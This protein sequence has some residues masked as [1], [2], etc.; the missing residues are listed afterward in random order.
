MASDRDL[1]QQEE[2]VAA[3]GK[4]VDSD[5]GFCMIALVQI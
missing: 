2:S 1:V 4:S 3:M 5:V